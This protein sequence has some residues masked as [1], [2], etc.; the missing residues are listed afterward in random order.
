MLDDHISASSSWEPSTS[1]SP[2]KKAKP[3]KDQ[4]S[5]LQEWMLPLLP[6]VVAVA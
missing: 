1:T 3:E 5:V 2:A 4:D 6:T